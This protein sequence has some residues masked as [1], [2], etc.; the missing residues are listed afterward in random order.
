MF[1]SYFAPYCRFIIWWSIAGVA[2]S[3]YGQGT[4]ASTCP[5]G[6]AWYYDGG[7]LQE[8]KDLCIPF[9]KYCYVGRNQGRY[10]QNYTRDALDL[11]IISQTSSILHL[12]ASVFSQYALQAYDG[13]NGI[14]SDELYLSLLKYWSQDRVWNQT[15]AQVKFELTN[16]FNEIKFCVKQYP[17]TIKTT[18]CDFK[19]TIPTNVNPVSYTHLTLPTKA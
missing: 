15:L 9:T 11:E 14:P 19:G 8:T 5:G 6:N 18:V 17:T 12:N 16:I 1:E 3:N 13:L 10:W 7:V 4:A 2:S